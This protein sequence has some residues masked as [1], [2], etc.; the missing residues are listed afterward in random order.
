MEC[1]S[2]CFFFFFSSRRRHTRL[3]CDWS[4][5]CALPI[6]AEALAEKL[7]L[8][9]GEVVRTRLAASLHDIGKMAIPDEILEKPGPLS[10]EEWKFVRRHTLV[11]ERILR[12]EERRVGKEC[13]AR[14][15]LEESG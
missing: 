12:S 6:F 3:T 7:G 5:D 14:R 4:S 10:D 11:G 9:R 15:G 8:S 1:W 2:F 13:R